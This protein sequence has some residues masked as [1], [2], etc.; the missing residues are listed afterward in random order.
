MK[1]TSPKL[2]ALHLPANEEALLRC[3]SALELK[4]KGNYKGAQEILRPLWK[5][6]GD[7]PNITGLHDSVAAEVLLCSGILTCW[8]GSKSH[9]SEAQ[10]TAKDLIGESLRYFQSAGDLTKAA[11]A[12][13]ELAYCYWCEGAL[14]EAR[15]MFTEALGKL[16]VEGN[17]RARAVL[18]LAA[19]EWSASRYKVALD[20][21]NSNT[22]LFKRISNHTTKGTLQ[23]GGDGA[24]KDS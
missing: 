17:T 11:A 18:G 22:S 14:D 16:T 12:R 23:S 20:I 1:I 8:L 4:D 15:I 6:V 7:R 2:Q 19:V 24:P 21:L 10:E 5:F 3:Q 9:L 13:A